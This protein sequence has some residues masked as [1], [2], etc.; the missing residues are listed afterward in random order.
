MN[1]WLSW[2]DLTKEEKEQ[3][4]ESY[5]YFREQEEEEP[6]SRKR[7]EGEVKCCRFERQD[8]GYIFVNL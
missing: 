3:A 6:C 1:N 2:N 5:R 8:D 4:I 7:A